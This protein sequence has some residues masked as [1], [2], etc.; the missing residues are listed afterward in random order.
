VRRLVR[1]EVDAAPLGCDL[2]FSGVRTTFGRETLCIAGRRQDPIKVD[3][4]L[5]GDQVAGALLADL[6]SVDLLETARAS[7]KKP[8]RAFASGA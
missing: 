3:L 5:V 4:G 6:Q 2:A 8:W 7:G 1:E